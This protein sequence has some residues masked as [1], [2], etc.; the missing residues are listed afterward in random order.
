MSTAPAPTGV[1]CHRSRSR[2]RRRAW[3]CRHRRSNEYGFSFGGPIKKDEA[4]FFFAYDGK[5]IED[6]RQVVPQN[7]GLL[8]AGLGIVPSLVRG[9]G[10]PGGQVQRAPAVRQGRSRSSATSSTWL[11]AC[12][13][14]ASP[15][16]C[17]RTATSARPGNDKNRSN[18][19][20]ASTCQAR[21]D[22]RRLAQR[23]RARLR[24]RGLEP[25]FDRPPRPSSA[26]RSRRPTRSSSGSRRT[27]STPA[28][29]PTRRSAARRAPTW[30]RT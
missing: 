22:A 11:P 19:E 8:P 16:T 14:A 13:C 3:R 4:H 2:R 23:V 29:R 15:T 7:L 24:E 25:A 9:P 27:S 28:A 21:V 20:T 26:T 12:A 17:P 18:D 10:Q 30:P 5:R 6:S 1:R